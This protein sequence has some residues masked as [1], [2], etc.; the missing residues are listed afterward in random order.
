MTGFIKGIT[1]YANGIRILTRFGLWGYALIPGLISALLG[2][3]IFQAAWSWSDDVGGWIS[4]LWPFDWGKNTLLRIA[5]VFGGLLIGMAGLIV[6]KQVVM[7]IASPF[8]SFLSENIEKRIATGKSVPFSLT[9]ALEDL[10]RG[11]RISIRN[12]IQELLYTFLLLLLGLIPIFSPFVAVAIFFVQAYY[13][14]FGNMDF[15]LERYHKVRDSV[16]FVRHHR[17]FAIGNGTIFLLLLFTGVGFL[18]ALPLATAAA[19]P[20]V[21]KWVKAKEALSA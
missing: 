6:F 8:M 10:S 19:T 12:I 4:A 1:A 2:F 3:L 5:N 7:A 16:H 14:G 13:A 20:E 21:L 9:K 15:T 11:I 18:F 17:G